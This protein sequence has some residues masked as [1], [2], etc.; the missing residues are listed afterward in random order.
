MHAD[1]KPVFHRDIRWPNLVRDGGD[2]TKWILID[3][4]D[5][6]TSLTTAAMHLDPKSH[7]PGVFR[8][9]HGAEVDIW[10]VGKLIV[11]AMVFTS[12]IPL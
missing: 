3:W 10:A 1:P 7:H 9:G 12:D 2:R 11:D 4:D 5:A 8:G 6:A